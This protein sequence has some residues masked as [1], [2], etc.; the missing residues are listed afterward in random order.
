MQPAPYKMIAVHFLPAAKYAMFSWTKVY[1]SDWRINS[2]DV[3]NVIT[4]VK[5]PESISIR[6]TSNE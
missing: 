3:K 1:Q 6:E 4:A 2:T 5:Q